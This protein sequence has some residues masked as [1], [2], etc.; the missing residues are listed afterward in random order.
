VRQLTAYH[1]AALPVEV[2]VE[3]FAGSV[4]IETELRSTA[5]GLFP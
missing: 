2:L 3:E 4:L 5:R 1:S